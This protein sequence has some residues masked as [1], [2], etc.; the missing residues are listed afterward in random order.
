MDPRLQELLDHQAIVRLMAEYAHACDRCDTERMVA[1][2]WED[3]WDDHGTAQDVGPAFARKMSEQIIPS[4][5]QTLSHLL[6]Q[7]LIEIDGDT[8]GAETYYIAVTLDTAADGEPRCSKLGGRYV[9]RLEKR[10]GEW[11]IKHR[12]CL[13]DWSLSL[14]VDE[15]YFAHAQLK[16]G[17]RTGED[18][19]YPVLGW[20][21]GAPTGEAMQ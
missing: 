7:S 14:R 19:S 10:G 3:S 9:D 1:C 16:P 17:H 20:R 13:R 12:T 4:S 21:H 18:M 5:C 6:G 2:Y 15:D 8:A 11:R